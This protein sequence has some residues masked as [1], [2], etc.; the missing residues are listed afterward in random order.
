M[1]RDG[2]RRR[3]DA[4]RVVERPVSHRD[5]ERDACAIVTAVGGAL[6][7]AH[8]HGLLHRDVKPANIL[9]STQGTG[10]AE[11]CWRTSA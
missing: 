3:T 8:Q 4:A 7:Y 5:A 9:V 11:S 2:L 1:D 10:D 6:D